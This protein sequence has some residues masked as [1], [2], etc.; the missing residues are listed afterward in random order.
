VDGTHFL[1]EVVYNN[2]G[3][4]NTGYWSF[5]YN[6]PGL[7]YEIA[8]SIFS[9]QIVWVNGPY[10]AGMSDL[11]IFKEKGLS[12]LLIQAKERAV[13][14][15]TYKHFA[16]SQRGNGSHEW[17]HAKNRYRARQESVNRRLKIFRCLQDRWR[18][19]HD[20]HGD[21]VRAIAL[22]TQLSFGQNPLMESIE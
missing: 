13:A 2:D 5:K 1:I 16:V 22:L 9:D 21:V 12:N 3:T 19:D 11:K 18:H 15:G 17:K 8:V 14:D 20:F 4:K 7:A 6:H 10:R